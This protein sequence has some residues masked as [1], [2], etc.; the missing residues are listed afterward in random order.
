VHVSRPRRALVAALCALGVVVGCTHTPSHDDFG[1]IGKGPVSCDAILGDVSTALRSIGSLTGHGDASSELTSARQDIGVFQFHV[2]QKRRPA[3]HKLYR[4]VAALQMALATTKTAAINSGAN[5]VAQRVGKVEQACRSSRLN[6]R[7][8]PE[9]PAGAHK[10]KHIIVVMQENR[11]FDHYF[12]TFPGADGIP[13]KNGVP[14]VCIPNPATGSCSRPQHNS[15]DLDHGGPHTYDDTVADID[16]GKMDGFIRQ[17]NATRKFC[18]QAGNTQG[19]VCTAESEHPDVVSYHDDREIPNY[20][21][22]AKR[23]VL[24]DHMFE[25]IRGWSQP[26]HLALVSGWSAVCKTPY[27]AITCH[28]SAT[29]NDIDKAWPHQPSYAWTDLTYLLHKSHVSWRYYVAPG[30]VDDCE[31]SND[32]K[33]H[34]TPGVKNFDPIGTPVPWNPLPDFTTVR[35]DHQVRNVQ[36]SPKFFKAAREGTLP[37]VTW[38]EPG[39][40]DSEHPPTLVSRGQAWVTRVVNAIMQGPDWKSSAIFVAWDDWGGFYDHVKPPRLD[41]F[42]YGLRVPAFMIS[43]YAKSGTIDHQTLSFDAYLR[44]I[45]DLF[46]KGQRIDPYTDGRWDPRPRVAEEAPQ[47]GNLLKEFDFRQKPLAPVVLPTYPNGS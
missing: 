30:S 14:T 15:S 44:L 1:R 4:A 21:E 42:S 28:T 11:S 25:P 17:W 40:Y 31:G 32:D 9:L 38:V 29:F 12:G 24:Q 39:W 3:V 5:S 41:K 16:G 27:L 43:P 36:R 23:F 34:C 2:P 19:R 33:I 35:D 18:L 26:A 45:E 46:M 47:L 22:Y 20:W 7:D 10:L 13:M 37:S 6:R 8:R